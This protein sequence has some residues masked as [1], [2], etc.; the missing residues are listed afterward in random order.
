M[1]TSIPSKLSLS[2]GLDTKPLNDG[3]VEAKNQLKGFEGTV[4]NMGN[5]FDKTFR[6]AQK[7]IEG[8]TMAAVNF[9]RIVQ[10][11]PFGL[12]GVSNNLEPMLQSF[13][14]LKSQ[15]GSTGGALKALAGSMF[16]GPGA[17]I[18]V[19][20]LAT[21]GLLM[22]GDKMSGA[23]KASEKAKAAVSAFSSG[24]DDLIKKQNALKFGEDQDLQAQLQSAN[25]EM[26]I[27]QGIVDQMRK[28][29]DMSSD[30][31]IGALV[32]SGQYSAAAIEKI[33]NLF[34]T[35]INMSERRLVY[36]QTLKDLEKKL[37]EAKGRK[38][39]I[40]ML[41]T[42]EK[43][44]QL[45]IA[46]QL[47]EVDKQL[48]VYADRDKRNEG[49]SSIGKDTVEAT[50]NLGDLS[51]ALN[52]MM[53]QFQTINTAST[54]A[55]NPVKFMLA[56]EATRGVNQALG[57]LQNQLAINLF[58]TNGLSDS[59]KTFGKT[60]TAALKSVIAKM[61][62][63]AALQGVGSLILKPLGVSTKAL[64]ALG[65][66]PFG[67][68]GKARAGGGQSLNANLYID[69]QNVRTTY[70]IANRRYNRIAGN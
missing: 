10:D 17:L 64:D 3:F 67:L 36:E 42:S 65:L 58:Q 19:T 60:A 47:L 29:S 52:P 70:E 18:T 15:T 35:T 16:S 66:N 53:E 8:T 24:L 39:G 41:T 37:I 1:A 48:A 32:G 12:M 2:L 69:G 22:F 59:F 45:A 40:E 62:V 21:T 55:F 38:L 44:T 43:A 26:E 25:N 4:G 61:A 54:D 11:M 5:R 27:L 6:M 56:N 14:K 57:S 51:A 31:I 46:N 50:K 63:L 49:F 28:T 7:P 30:G 20:S 68:I 13:S 23:G 9:N 34:G 33:N